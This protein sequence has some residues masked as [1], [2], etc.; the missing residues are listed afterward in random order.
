M[1]LTLRR[2]TETQWTTAN[3]IL[4]EGEVG[5]ATDLG[6]YK[7]GDGVSTWSQ[8]SYGHTT[9]NSTVTLAPTSFLSTPAQGVELSLTESK[10]L[11]AKSPTQRVPLRYSP[12][13]GEYCQWQATTG[14]TA[15][16]ALFGGNVS[17]TSTGTVSALRFTGSTLTLCEQLPRISVVSTATTTSK[18]EI[19]NSA[20]LAYRNRGFM[21]RFRFCNAT[22]NVSA[23][24]LVGHMAFISTSTSLVP[25]NM[26]NC[27]FVGY[28]TADTG[29]Q[30]MHNDGSGVCTKVP[31]GVNFPKAQNNDP[32]Y[33]VSFV[34]NPGGDILWEVVRL[35]TT[36]IA[37]GVISTNLPDAAT[38]MSPFVY[39]NTGGVATAT[40]PALLEFSQ[41]Q[42]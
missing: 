38:F 14:T 15:F 32:T 35:G 8:L 33:Q 30:V 20:V 17:Y 10:R 31:L 24:M 37:T 4:A 13:I 6:Q 25:S 18:A 16:P 39:S 22:S 28:D 41:H 26:V 34:A 40:S 23:Q 36:H 12:A 29:L 42:P 7:I 9:E 21:S 3:P 27:V 11:V 5:F 19:T 1:T 2:G